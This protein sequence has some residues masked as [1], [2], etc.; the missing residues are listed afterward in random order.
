MVLGCACT[1]ESAQELPSDKPFVRIDFTQKKVGPDAGTFDLDIKSNT[2]WTAQS[3]SWIQVTPSSAKGSKSL[4]VTYSAIEGQP[5]TGTIRFSSENANPATFTLTQSSEQ[6]RTFKNPIFQPLPDPYFWR[7]SDGKTVTYYL[8]KSSGRAVNIGKSNSLISPGSTKPI[9][10]CPSDGAE[11]VWNNDNL[12]APELHRIDGVWYIYYAAGRP[13]SET[14]GSYVTQR[15]GVLRCRDNDPTTGTWEDM[16]MIFTGDETDF[17]AYKRTRKA[18]PDNT[19][20][21][22]DMT[23]FKMGKQLYAIWSGNASKTDNAQR[24]YIATMDNPWT[25]NCAR[26]ELSCAELGWEK[27]NNSINEGPS[28]LF[29]PDGTRLFCVYSANGSWTKEYRLGWLELDLSGSKSDPMLPSNWKKSSNYVFWRSDNVAKSS[30]PTSEDAKNKENMHIGGVHG[31]GHNSFTKSPDGSEDW[32]IYHTKRYKDSGWDNR[33]CFIQ[34]FSW[35][36]NGTPNFGKPV[37]WQEAIEIP[38]GEL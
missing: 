23:V 1:K 38:S 17:S 6:V 37:G 36:T 32:I 22:I 9:W 14:N 30:N 35:N 4:S 15:T 5:R 2:L 13:T 7:E 10:R 11:K 18:T 34:K 16:G 19:I 31:V 28:I 25:I 21:A 12:W 8:C 20:Y 24:L 29:N 27:V 33:D 3:D 26:V